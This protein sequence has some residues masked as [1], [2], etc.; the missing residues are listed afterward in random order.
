MPAR[1]HDT[2]ART[3][4]RLRARRRIER[5]AIGMTTLALGALAIGVI[6]AWLRPGPD[7]RRVLAALATALALASL[8][9]LR[10]DRR[11]RRAGP[12]RAAATLERAARIDTGAIVSA[13]QLTTEADRAPLA[14]ALTERAADRGAT[15]ADSAAHHPLTGARRLRLHAAIAL[16]ACAIVAVAAIVEPRFFAAPAARLLDPGARLPAWSRATLTLH[17]PNAELLIGDDASIEAVASDAAGPVRLEVLTS[18][19][20]GAPALD[21][22]PMRALDGDRFGATLRD[23]REPVWLVAIG[24]AAESAPIRLEPVARPRIEQATVE[25][26]GSAGRLLEAIEAGESID[27]EAAVGDEITLRAVASIDLA[28]A[29]A[30]GADESAVAGRLASASF[31]AAEPGEFALSLRPVGPTGL[32]AADAMTVTVRVR[33]GAGDSGESVADAS[34]GAGAGGDAQAQAP[35]AASPST[36]GPNIALRTP[37]APPPALSPDAPVADEALIAIESRALDAGALAPGVGIRRVPQA[38]RARVGAYFLR[39]L[40][41]EAPMESP[42]Q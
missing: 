7:G 10:L 28:G 15:L 5:L 30:T 23:L 24:D 38:Y 8:W 14:R 42:E 18:D 29:E 26:A 33:A 35:D 17:P 12:L 34:E 25:R 6:D 4:R 31:T 19:R 36:D 21:T 41:D 20:A 40:R 16:C 3:L 9:T 1:L 37:D 39:L 13:A 11:T 2:L 32:A 27:L 22:I